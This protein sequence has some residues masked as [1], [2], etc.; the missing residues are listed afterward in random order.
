MTTNC[1]AILLAPGDG[2]HFRFWS[3]EEFTWKVTGASSAGALDVGELLVQPGIG[4]PEHIHHANDETFF[5]LDGTF[6]FTTGGQEQT[7]RAGAFV[8]IP[9]G[10]PHHWANV[11]DAP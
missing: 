2:A 6:Q 10:V 4:V 9:R 1:D 7:I 3:G 8:F 11:G 5:V